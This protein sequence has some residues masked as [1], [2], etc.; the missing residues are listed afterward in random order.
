M[1]KIAGI[2]AILV[3]LLLVALQIALNSDALQKRAL[4]FASENIDAEIGMSSIDISV[5]K[6]FPK[7]SVELDSVSLTY[8]HERF[9]SYDSLGLQSRLLRSG[10]G[11]GADTLARF[12]RLSVAVNAWS[13]LSGRVNV[14]E[15]VLSGTVLY[16]HSYDSTARNWDIFRSSGKEDND[17]ISSAPLSTPWISLGRIALDGGTSVVYTDQAD[18]LFAGIFI[19]DI[20]LKGSVRL[21]EGFPQM[22]GVSFGIDRLLAF[23][24][25]P[26]DTLTFRLDSLLLREKGRNVFGLSLGSSAR[27]HTYAFGTVDVPFSL[28]S[29]FGISAGEAGPE[30]SLNSLDARFAG[31]PLYAAGKFCLSDDTVNLDA[32]AGIRDMELSPLLHYYGARL[33]DEADNI[34]TDLKLN[35]DATAKGT[36]SGDAFPECRATLSVP[37]SE[38]GYKPMGLVARLKLEAD[39]VMDS[40]RLVS[41][42]VNELDFEMPGVVAK[43][44]GAA[45]DLLGEDPFF[46]LSAFLDAHLDKLKEFLPEDIIVEGDCTAELDAACLKSQIETGK[47]G[48]ASVSGKI[49]GERLS[50]KLPESELD[51]GLSGSRIEIRSSKRGILLDMKVDSL[52][53]SNGDSLSVRVAG[54]TNSGR[55][56]KNVVEGKSVPS[57]SFRTTEKR[58]A[59]RYGGS[60]MM[61]R[62]SDISLSIRKKLARQ[63]RSLR[64]RTGNL[65]TLRRARTI[66]IPDFMKEKDFRKNDIKL[67]LSDSTRNILKEW[68]PSGS[69]SMNRVFVASPMFPLRTRING[70][71][72]NF[73]GNGVN[74]ENLSITSGTS[75]LTAKGKVK[76]LRGLLDGRGMVYAD[77]DVHSGRLNLNEMNAALMLG[78]RTSATV[79]SDAL[80]LGEEDESF[81]VDTLANT[82]EAISENHLIVVPGNVVAQFRMVVDSL[83]FNDIHA[84]PFTAGMNMS[85]RCLQLNNTLLHSNYG[86]MSLD[87]FYST[88]SK[89]DISLSA[90][91]HLEKINAEQIISLLP[92]VDSLMP[93]L[94]SFKGELG[95]NLSF[96]TKLDTTMK[97][98]LPSVDGVLR[99][100]GENLYI[101]DAGSLRKITNL[102]MFRNKNIGSIDN[103]YVNGF[104]HGNKAEIFPFILGVDRY[105]LALGGTQNFDRSFNYHVSVLKS[106]LLVRFGI[107]IFGNF[108]K[109]KF[110]LGKARYSE[111]IPVYTTELDNVHTDILSGIRNILNRSFSYDFSSY[112]FG[113]AAP[114]P[115]EEEDSEASGKITEALIEYNMKLDEVEADEAANAAVSS[116]LSEEK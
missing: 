4:G 20:G 26:K 18:T 44:N 108:D 34:D 60:R 46:K 116:V 85:G 107:N 12:N 57:M 96:T 88:K 64:S 39:A 82:T 80:S 74:L 49:T 51:A 87:A 45:R 32:K 89:D 23:C 31:I 9:A 90:D 76:G 48:D 52:A 103:M 6:R 25:L 97:P 1:L 61:V 5:L 43:V 95:C 84:T 77:L 28:D 14:K 99:I 53:L 115:S 111:D 41:A 30:I 21:K 54:M 11:A 17:T 114:A 47:Y 71:D 104:V 73:D 106:P 92:V 112:K 113:N 75:D 27:L 110:S 63:R 2:A 15:L 24:R 33:I 65:D 109:W 59:A 67:D 19:G 100:A 102:L 42:S 29:D 36:F 94:K 81:V 78:K 16:A 68:E 86:D 10:R 35:L 56:E 101:E 3:A 93:M 55:L 37:R 69:L 91:L 58:I 22:R 40:A 50:L 7:I 70:L 13:L 79:S 66:E 83:N 98:I 38:F 8:P 62:D 72:C 105:K